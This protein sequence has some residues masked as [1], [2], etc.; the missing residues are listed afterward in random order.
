MLEHGETD[1]SGPLRK[2][3]VGIKMK[4][5]FIASGRGYAEDIIELL[6]VFKGHG[7]DLAGFSGV[8][9]MSVERKRTI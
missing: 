9:I 5:V 1:A 3:M 2:R 6:A 4:K 8:Y 7:W